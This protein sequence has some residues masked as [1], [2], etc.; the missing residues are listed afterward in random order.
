MRKLTKRDLF[1]I[2]KAKATILLLITLFIGSNLSVAV[3]AE[4]KENN[5][6]GVDTPMKIVSL[7][8]VQKLPFSIPIL[9]IEETNIIEVPE[10][11]THTNIPVFTG[12]ITSNYGWRKHPIKHTK[13]HHD[14]IDI[15]AKRN[16]PL[17]APAIGR[18]VFAGVMSGYGKVIRIDHL[19]GYST[20][21]A[22]L[23]KISVTV[24]EMIKENQ[25]IGKTG[26]TG[27]STG[28]HVHIEVFHYNK[29]INPIQFVK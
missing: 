17:Y 29:R 13:K 20:L 3:A 25:I 23:D 15:A 12:I 18:I 11:I 16:S 10:F 24:G 2:S 14:G 19:N 8:P 4:H 22:H 1:S 5:Y 26:M 6:N 9:K 7:T 28:P 21:L 27:L